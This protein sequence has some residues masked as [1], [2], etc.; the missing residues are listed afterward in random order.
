MASDVQR[1]YFERPNV[2]V[3]N[4]DFAQIHEAG[5]NMIRTGWWT[6][7]DKLC[8]ENGQPS[9]RTL[10]TLEAYLMTA[11]RYRLPVQFTFF[12]F[13]PEVLGG[14]NP[15]LD[16]EAVHRQQTLVSA[17]TT[18]FHDIPFLAWDL[19]NEPSF[20]RHLWTTRPNGDALELQKWNE[21][22][23]KRYPDRAA[24]AAAWN[25]P[26]GE[27]A[28][29]IHI[30]T[31][32]EFLQRGVY[33]GHNSLKLYDF[34]LFVQETFAN[35]AE[36]MRTAVRSTGS[37]QLVTVGQDEG[38][39]EG[40]PSPA[41]WVESV[42]FTTNHSWWE[43]DFLLWDSLLAKQ[44]GKPL[45]IQETGFQRELNP[46]EIARRTP[47]NEA[48]IIE[49]KLAISLIQ[50]SGSIEW[51]WNTNSYMTLG[52]ETCIG[53]LRTDG[54]EKPEAD[55]LRRFAGFSKSL[56][57]HMRNPQQ[58]SIAIVTSQAAEYSVQSAL[59][60]EAQRTA[61][62]ALSY[63]SRLATYV[64][65]ENQIARLGSPQLVVLPSPQALTDK[66]W[67]ALLK[68]VSDGGN[69]LVTG[70]VDS[71]EHWHSTSRIAALNLDAQAEPL[72]Y[73]VATLRLGDHTIPL[74]FDQEKQ[75]LLTSLR[76]NDRSSFKEISHGKGRIFWSAYPVELAEGSQAARDLYAYV[77]GR[78]GI[79]SAFALQAPLSSGVLVYS[80]TLDD[81]VLYV[82]SSE[83]ADETTIDLRDK[84]TG[85]RLK[86]R[87]PAQRAALALIGKQ[88][89]TVL[90]RYGY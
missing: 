89:K 64:I 42:D 33:A 60:L 6:G 26:A 10:R 31:D 23:D 25:L 62:R 76:F 56:A 1:L 29:T 53:A 18:R 17:V 27:V 34:F 4:R 59:Q 32:A 87:L 81:S 28:G 52:N 70:A 80:L 7:W 5:F 49:R 61:I 22:L 13:L 88:Q 3:W 44:P 65:A 2:F 14:I 77:A 40:R 84:S 45:L 74:S 78:L 43:N 16:P 72:T 24:L 36:S 9:E 57:E 71:D 41:Y 82:M 8:D 46:D 79:S 30:P 73:H 75:S 38:G 90:A 68:Y 51:L 55:V 54:T 69:L 66:A 15:Y 39:I 63:D 37:H 12:A 83:S 35:W 19:I 48:A 20:S 50:G 47:E 58:P 21:W 85:V 67:S 11:R 86:L